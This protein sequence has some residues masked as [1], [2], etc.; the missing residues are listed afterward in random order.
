M[1][2]IICKK[3]KVEMK[4]GI[5][6]QEETSVSPDFIGDN[7]DSQIIGTVYP[8]GNVKLDS[9]YKCPNCGHSI[10][11]GKEKE[12]KYKKI[13]I[14]GEAC[15]GKTTCM[16]YI[17]KIYKKINEK[18]II[19]FMKFAEPHY[20]TLEILNQ[21][22]NRLFMQEFSDL[23]KKHFGESIFVDAFDANVKREFPFHYISNGIIICD[24]LR[25][26]IEYEYARKNEWYIIYIDADEKIRKERSDKLGLKWNPNHSSESELPLFK[27]KCDAII[28]N[29]DSFDCFY[30][31]IDKIITA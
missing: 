11:L 14:C 27:N 30:E 5:Y 16:N 4:P 20:Q 23:A 9:C 26:L 15:S 6:L 28:E 18:C 3:C 19:Y 1:K 24:D 22:K 17:T 25:Y 10:L 2:N 8:N 21:Q 13:M 12:T 29:N 31:Q 7:P